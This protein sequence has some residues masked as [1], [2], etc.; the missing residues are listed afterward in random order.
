M[1]TRAGVITKHLDEH[2]TKHGNNRMSPSSVALSSPPLSSFLIVAAF[3]FLCFLLVAPL[4]GLEDDSRTDHGI[5][6]LPKTDH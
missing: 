2:S 5:P 3:G 6:C 1:G 4:P